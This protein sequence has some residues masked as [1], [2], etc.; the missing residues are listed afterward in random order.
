M[1]SWYGQI[2]LHHTSLLPP[3][4]CILLE[5]NG[6]PDRRH[7]GT[8]PMGFTEVRQNLHPEHRPPLGG[9]RTFLDPGGADTA[10]AK[11]LGTC[12]CLTPYPLFTLNVL[13][14]WVTFC[15][16]SLVLGVTGLQSQTPS[17]SS[18]ISPD[19]KRISSTNKCLFL[20]GYL[21]AKTECRFSEWVS[22]AIK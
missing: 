6:N 9:P 10:A 22:V 18:Q 5:C 19:Q 16:R 17:H 7:R 8:R 21:F 14:L 15:E 12:L 11:V 4:G 2:R 1:Q 20:S 3:W 13:E